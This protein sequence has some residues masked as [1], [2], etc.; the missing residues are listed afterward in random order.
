M[1]WHC[2][3]ISGRYRAEISVN[4]H[5]KHQNLENMMLVVLCFDSKVSI[6]IAFLIKCSVS[7][8]I[9]SYLLQ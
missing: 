2:N 3:V 8:H 5:S 1:W 4:V 6:T 7:V 9:V